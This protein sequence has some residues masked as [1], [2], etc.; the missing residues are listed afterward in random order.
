M[1]SL[2]SN[3][4]ILCFWGGGRCWT[5]FRYLLDGGRRGADRSAHVTVWY[6]A[7]SMCALR[8]SLGPLTRRLW[9]AGSAG[10]RRFRTSLHIGRHKLLIRYSLLSLHVF[11]LR[12]LWQRYALVAYSILGIFHLFIYLMMMM[13]ISGFSSF[14]FRLHSHERCC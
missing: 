3:Q 4:A 13:M 8:V 12:T 10:R 5:G 7:G 9:W 2:W 14:G 1:T 11:S 6:R